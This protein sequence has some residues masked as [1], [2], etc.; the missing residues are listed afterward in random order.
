MFC[1]LWEVGW[2]LRSWCVHWCSLHNGTRAMVPPRGRCALCCHSA[3]I[4]SRTHEIHLPRRRAWHDD[5][6]QFE[7]Q[8][9]TSIDDSRNPCIFQYER[10]GI[11][12]GSYSSQQ[13]RKSRLVHFSEVGLFAC[14]PFTMSWICVAW[15][16]LSICIKSI[17]ACLICTSLLMSVLQSW[18]MHMHAYTL[19]IY[20]HIIIYFV[21]FIGRL[22]VAT[23]WRLCRAKGKS[24]ESEEEDDDDD[25]EDGSGRCWDMLEFV[26]DSSKKHME[27][28]QWCFAGITNTPL[29]KW[30]QMI[31]SFFCKGLWLVFTS[32][33][34]ESER[35]SND[36]TLHWALP[37]EQEGHGIELDTPIPT[38]SPKGI[39]P[40]TQLHWEIQW[41]ICC[42][43]S[44]LLSH[45]RTCFFV[46]IYDIYNRVH[47]ISMVFG[48][49]WKIDLVTFYHINVENQRRNFL[50]KKWN[51]TGKPLLEISILNRLLCRQHI[52]WFKKKYKFEPSRPLH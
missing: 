17:E 32:T 36:A 31:S 28:H 12:T 27:F 22:F 51:S 16:D 48:S 46:W 37:I 21:V 39:Y 41:M 34:W 35:V 52:R 24:D 47:V 9:E 18:T 30:I 15:C 43:W 3:A 25:V 49:L 11:T 7:A 26:I 13:F 1:T 40:A 8:W 33:I 5:K 6:F 23:T 4:D 45:K 38:S 19:Y 50:P 44:F 2:C 14:T 42:Q 10:V 20:I 29:V